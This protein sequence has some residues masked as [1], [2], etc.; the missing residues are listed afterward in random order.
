MSFLQES[1]MREYI[2][3]PS[4]IPISYNVQGADSGIFGNLNNISNGGL[5]FCTTDAIVINTFIVINFPIIHSKANLQG[6]VVWCNPI[7]EVFDI[8]VKFPDKESAF[9]VRLIEQI[10]Y[11]E[12]YRRTVFLNEGRNLTSQQAALEW[13]EKFASDFPAI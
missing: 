4:D 9:R 3:H 5:C 2:R 7:N 6:I 12:H 1:L 13:I 11:I 8:G 10:C